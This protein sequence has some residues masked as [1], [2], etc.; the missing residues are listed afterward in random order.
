[1]HL[2][3]AQQNP[4]LVGL[5]NYGNAFEFYSNSH[6]KRLEQLMQGNDRM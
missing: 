5:E 1:M 4:G 6:R 3:K 2:G